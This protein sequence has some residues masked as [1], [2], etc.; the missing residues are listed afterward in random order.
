MLS[1]APARMA[2]GCTHRRLGYQAAF[3]E[4]YPYAERPGATQAAVAA[5]GAETWRVEAIPLSPE[6]LGAKVSA[7]GYYRT[8]MA[9]LFHGAEAMPNR[10]WT[11]AASRSPQVP[12][13]ER[14]WWPSEA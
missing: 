14:L 6:D 8:Q 5:A 4:D 3:Y 2:R 13:A 11:F 10:V 9:V 12:L 1:T 7:L